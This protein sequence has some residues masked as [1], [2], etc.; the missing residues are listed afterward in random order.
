MENLRGILAIYVASAVPVAKNILGIT[1]SVD[2]SAHFL[3]TPDNYSPCVDFCGRIVKGV[4]E[5]KSY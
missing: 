2:V 5:A 1:F 4:V 3:V